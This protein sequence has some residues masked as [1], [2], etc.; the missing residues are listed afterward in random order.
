MTR[1]STERIIRDYEKLSF[2]YEK[3]IVDNK[4]LNREN[5]EFITANTTLDNELTEVNRQHS[6]TSAELKNAINECDKLRAENVRLTKALGSFDKR[7]KAAVKAKVNAKLKAI[8]D[9]AM[10]DEEEEDN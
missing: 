6:S 9:E 10:A 7:V 8:A 2:N 3:L 4:K 1:F 5:R